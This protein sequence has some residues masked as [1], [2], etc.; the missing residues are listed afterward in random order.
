[1]RARGVF[2]AAGRRG[3]MAVRRREVVELVEA[4]RGLGVRITV[5]PGRNQQSIVIHGR[6][7]EFPGKLRRVAEALEALDAA[8]ASALSAAD[9][10]SDPSMDAARLRLALDGVFRWMRST[11][12]DVADPHAVVAAALGVKA[13]KPGKGYKPVPKFAHDGFKRGMR[14]K[15]LLRLMPQPGEKVGMGSIRQKA[16]QAEMV[17]TSLG[18]AAPSSRR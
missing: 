15:P 8:G 2:P 4:A 6:R 17:E 12:I 14:P 3:K 16:A 7:E 18:A 1:M 10:G 9:P 13:D 5:K 11:G